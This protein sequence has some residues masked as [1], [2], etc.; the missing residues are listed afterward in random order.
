LK[1]TLRYASGGVRVGDTIR[2]RDKCQRERDREQVAITDFAAY[3]SPAGYRPEGERLV[4]L[5]RPAPTCVMFA[6]MVMLLAPL[7][8][9]LVGSGT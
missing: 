5:P 6:I 8:A 7:V 3:D 4:S 1:A 9:G 2:S